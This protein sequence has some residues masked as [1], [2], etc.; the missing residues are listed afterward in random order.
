MSMNMSD[1][2]IGTCDGTGATIYVCLGF[3]PRKVRVY[4]VEDSDNLEPVL[5][6]NRE[7]DNITLMTD[8]IKTTALTDVDRAVLTTLGIDEY[9]GGTEITYDGVT[10]N[11]WEDADGNSV[12]EVYVNGHYQRSSDSSDAYQCIGDA[13]MGSSTPR[14]GAKVKTPCGFSIGADTAINVDGE[15]LVWEVWR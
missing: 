1:S 15:R 11:R 8:G 6:W 13:I 9:D 14:D 5:D 12:E 10:N 4:N 2:V 3:K 7:I